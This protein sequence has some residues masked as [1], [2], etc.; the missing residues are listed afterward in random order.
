MLSWR[1]GRRWVLAVAA[2]VATVGATSLGHGG[3]ALAQVDPACWEWVAPIIGTGDDGNPVYGAERLVYTCGSSGDGS[4]NSGPNTCHHDEFGTVPCTNSVHGWWSNAEQCYVRLK[5][6]QPSAGD[7]E[8]EGHD[9][10][11][12]AVYQ[13]ACP[14]TSIE[15]LSLFPRFMAG[16]PQLPSPAVLAQRA[17]ETLPL[18]GPDI[19]IAPSPDGVGLVGV[20][21]WLWTDDADT[22]WGPIERSAS[23]PGL[24]V[25]AQA[26][27]SEIEWDMG[28]GTTEVCDSPGEPYQASYGAREPECGHSYDY[29]SSTQPDGRYHITATTVWY[30]QWWVEPQGSGASGED[31]FFRESSTS[32]QINELQVVTS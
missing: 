31:W 22:T 13:L 9:S 5:D 29:P 3:A 10:S 4:G 27:A 18:V 14:Q 21:V 30:V 2:V 7:S 23:V 16:E 15:D 19:G 11:E 17:M 25:T 8:W 1:S 20:P 24:T 6:P 32:I 28:D 12:G 26:Q